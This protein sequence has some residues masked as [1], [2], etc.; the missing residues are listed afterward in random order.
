MV[1]AIVVEFPTQMSS[2]CRLGGESR[3]GGQIKGSG[4]ASG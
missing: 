1:V 3:D 4:C 2:K